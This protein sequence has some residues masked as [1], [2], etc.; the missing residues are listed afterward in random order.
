MGLPRAAL[1]LSGAGTADP[2]EETRVAEVFTVGLQ[3]ASLLAT[4]AMQL[5]MPSMLTVSEQQ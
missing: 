2:I 4:E 5:S 3:Q 1:G